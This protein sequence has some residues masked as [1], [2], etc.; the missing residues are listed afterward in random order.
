MSI[1]TSLPATIALALL[2]GLSAAILA[3][4]NDDPATGGFLR[5]I[6]REH[7][8]HLLTVLLLE[9]AD[10]YYEEN[11]GPPDTPRLFPSPPGFDR[12]VA[13]RFEGS[14]GG[15][16]FITSNKSTITQVISYGA[17]VWANEDRWGRSAHDAIGLLEAHK[18]NWSISSLVK[19]IAGRR[20]PSL[21]RAHEDGDPEIIDRPPSRSMRNSFYSDSA[22]TAFTYMAYTDSILARR[23]RKDR[24]AR[25]WSAAGLYGLAGYVAYSRVERGQHYLS[26]V[27]AGAGAGFLVGKIVY[28]MNHRDHDRVETAWTIRPLIVPGGAGISVSYRPPGPARAFAPHEE[29]R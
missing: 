20:R 18:I 5:E 26:D 14:P 19:N 27:I 13:S 7:R 21:Q 16:D 23:F 6:W 17:I 29:V 2:H 3:S 9:N 24:R 8:Y 22:S 15:P 28:R 12:A 10:R 4:E 11:V 25:I 1:R